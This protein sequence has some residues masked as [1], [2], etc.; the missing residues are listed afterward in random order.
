M[1]LSYYEKFPDGTY[2]R[3]ELQKYGMTILAVSEH[4]NE[5]LVADMHMQVTNKRDYLIQWR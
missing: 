2:M 4:N 1:T 5:K 3:A